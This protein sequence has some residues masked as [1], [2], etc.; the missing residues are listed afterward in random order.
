MGDV[1]LTTTPK[2]AQVIDVGLILSVVMGQFVVFLRENGISSGEI[3]IDR[4]GSS[5]VEE[6]LQAGFQELMESFPDSALPE[7]NKLIAQ[8]VNSVI[9]FL[10]STTEPMIQIA[11][12]VS[13]VIWAAAEGDNAFLL[14]LLEYYAPGRWKTYGIVVLEK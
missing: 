5:A 7:K 1:Y 4:M 6:R 3:W 13:G 12:F 14:D 9:K 10:D 2:G 8:R 11:D